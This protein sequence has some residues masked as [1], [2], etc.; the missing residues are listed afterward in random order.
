MTE[1]GSSTLLLR[2]LFS[3]YSSFTGFTHR[4]CSQLRPVTNS[5]IVVI[6]TIP[7]SRRRTAAPGTRKNINPESRRGLPCDGSAFVQEFGIW[8]LQVGLFLTFTTSRINLMCRRIAMLAG[9]F[10][11]NR[12]VSSFYSFIECG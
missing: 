2:R 10:R 7:V 5:A 9:R 11:S 8:V 6:T 1:M 12:S 4:H 3:R